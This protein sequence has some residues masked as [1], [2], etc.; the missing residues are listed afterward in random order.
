[1]NVLRI[2]LIGCIPY[3]FNIIYASAMMVVKNLKRAVAIYGGIAITTI[4]AGY[5][6]MLKFGLIGVEYA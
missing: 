6:L 5:L 1:L 4:I 2:L 3:S